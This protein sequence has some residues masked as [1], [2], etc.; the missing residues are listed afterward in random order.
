MKGDM[1][2]PRQL[3]PTAARKSKI[4]NPIEPEPKNSPVNSLFVISNTQNF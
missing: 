3:K 4:P 1:F 2:D